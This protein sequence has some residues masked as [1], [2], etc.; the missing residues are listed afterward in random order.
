MWF[1]NQ[2][3]AEASKTYSKQLTKNTAFELGKLLLI[4]GCSASS[5]N[6]RGSTTTIVVQPVDTNSGFTDRQMFIVRKTWKLLAT[7]LTRRGSKVFVKIF[8]L[9]PHV[10]GLFPFKN[11]DDANELLLDANF[12]G[13][14]SRFMNAVGA[15]V[16]NM[17]NLEE[18]L[19][20][21]L[22]GLGENH[23]K[24]E[25][26]KPEYFNSFSQAMNIVWKEDL[27]KRYT[28]EAEEA[29]KV[30]F[31]FIMDNLK[32]GFINAQAIQKYNGSV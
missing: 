28:T 15:V 5:N 24:F 3:R 25:G 20:P 29:W 31:A 13:H 32:V 17:D 1:V 19:A 2:L 6:R 21:L 10:K 26:F 22:I 8:E 30:V 9:N 14:A 4:M 7:D 18:S 12:K 27:G 23:V 16:D 11:L